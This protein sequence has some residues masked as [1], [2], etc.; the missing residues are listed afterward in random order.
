MHRLAWVQQQ[1]W[2]NHRWTSFE[3]WDT[4]QQAL[5]CTNPPCRQ[6]WMGA[7]A[8]LTRRAHSRETKCLTWNRRASL[9]KLR[10]WRNRE[11]LF[12]CKAV[13]AWQFCSHSCLPISL[14][15]R[16]LKICLLTWGLCGKYCFGATPSVLSQFVWKSAKFLLLTAT[17]YLSS[18][19]WSSETNRRGRSTPLQYYCYALT[20]QRD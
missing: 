18:V 12:A 17:F 15:H 5:S 2:P 4:L 20:Y 9:S 7:Q 1:S 16:D 14:T 6:L 3:F 8:W 13:L 10:D 19:W 11:S